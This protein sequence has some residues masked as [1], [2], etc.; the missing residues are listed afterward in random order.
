MSNYNL[1]SKFEEAL[2]HFNTTLAQASEHYKGLFSRLMAGDD[3]RSDIINDKYFHSIRQTREILVESQQRISRILEDSRDFLT[4]SEI[5][6]KAGNKICTDIVGL[7][8]E[9][10]KLYN[11]IASYSTSI[12]K[13]FSAKVN[14]YRTFFDGLYNDIQD[15]PLY[16]KEGTK[17]ENT[18]GVFVQVQV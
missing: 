16:T 10:V 3:I 2:M 8:E 12:E 11:E 14:E 4:L 15:N 1:F 13:Y 17:T 5:Q 6:D 18:Q 9:C 7:G